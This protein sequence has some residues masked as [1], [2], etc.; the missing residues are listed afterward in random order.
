MQQ[1]KDKAIVLGRIDYAERDRILTLLCKNQGKMSLIAKGTRAAKS[2]LAGGIELFSES[3]I[4]YIKGRGNVGTL[5]SSRLHQHFGR[6]IEDIERTMF[7]YECL[8]L[9][10]KIN[11][12]GSGQ[13]CYPLLSTLFAALNDPQSH[14]V[15]T[16]IWF[17]MQILDYMGTAPE[18][19]ISQD[20]KK[21]QAGASYQFDYD[22]QAFRIDENGE[23]T[24]DHVKFLRLCLSQRRPPKVVLSIEALRVADRFVQR[25]IQ[26]Q[27]I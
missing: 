12:D 17:F 22:K 7:A 1:L 24:A 23:F 5:T 15:L 19:Y 14:L 11:Q 25:L 2:K 27:Q 16:K 20:S 13:E 8:R 10:G 21:L 3:D 26:L 18:L 6:I 9:V 4:Q